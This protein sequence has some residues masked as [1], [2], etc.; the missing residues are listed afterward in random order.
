MLQ[1]RLKKLL[2]T[3]WHFVWVVVYF[4][5]HGYVIHGDMLP[6]RD[7]FLLTGGLLLLG[8]ILFGIHLKIFRNQ[9]KAGLFTS[10]LLVVILFYGVFQDLL[11]GFRPVH[12]L[13]RFLVFVPLC[14]LA[15]VAVFI[16]LKLTRRLLNKPLLFINIVLI[17][18]ILFDAASLI[19]HSPVK[20]VRKENTFSS[21]DTCSRP[22]VYLV[23]LDEYMGN[24]A[25]K[26]YFNYDNAA[27]QNYLLGEEFH[28][29]KNPRSNYST[30]MFSMASMLNMNYFN[31][32][33][34]VSMYNHY[35]YD[36]GLKAI[37]DN[38]VCVQFEHLG[39]QIVNYSPFTLK[40]KQAGYDTGLIPDDISILTS[41]TIWYRMRQYLPAFLAKKGILT[42]LAQKKD[43]KYVADNESMIA[44]TLSDSRGRTTIPTFHYVHLTMPHHPYTFDSTGRRTVPYPLRKRVTKAESDQDYLQFLVY[45]NKRI[46]AFISEL[47]KNTGNK[48][49]IL[50]MSDH[51]LRFEDQHAKLAFQNFNA[52]YLPGK[53]Y[54]G[55]YDG[56][57]NVNQF[58]VLFNT[59]FH[60]QLPMLKDSIAK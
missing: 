53:E 32:R 41:Q 45:T 30:T 8:I 26:Q 1:D 43:D 48:A 55:W 29:V 59:L 60:Q 19:F 28:I 9:R 56:M 47:K 6:L 40:Q 37:R 24:S 46:S 52:I 2:T 36:Y 50:V 25:L 51:G 35:A 12:A 34:A 20:E 4:S 54:A 39:Y 13:S 21:C 15:T 17:L 49:V 33:G 23:L 11:S 31:P 7:L 38:E 44:Q 10:F 3:N 42:G 18:Y 57:T 58:R 27:F 5:L 16:G 14:I 22:S